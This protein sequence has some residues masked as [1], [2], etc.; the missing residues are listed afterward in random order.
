MSS[1]WP[2]Y[3]GERFHGIQIGAAEHI[4]LCV[5]PSRLP[6]MQIL[7]QQLQDPNV[8]ILLISMKA[9]TWCLWLCRRD[10]CGGSLLSLAALGGRLGLRGARRLGLLLGRRRLCLCG[11]ASSLLR[12]LPCRRCRRRLRLLSGFRL[13]RGSLSLF[14]PARLGG[15][16][17]FGW[18]R[19]RVRPVSYVVSS[20]FYRA[21]W[22]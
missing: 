18:R 10:C 20:T 15:R 4:L 7:L 1:N 9:R 3:M 16:L 19:G 2:T 14:A 8:H 21:S 17:C 6:L 12:G 22:I 13:R 5:L 11:S